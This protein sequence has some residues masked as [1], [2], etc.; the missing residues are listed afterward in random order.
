MARL[1]GYTPIEHERALGRLLADLARMERERKVR[2]A[3]EPRVQSRPA[4]PASLPQ[5]H[6]P[7]RVMSTRV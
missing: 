2:A 5:F 7:P 3:L 1:D 4:R 6:I